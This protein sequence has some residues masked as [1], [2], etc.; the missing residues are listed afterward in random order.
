MHVHMMDYNN[1]LF[2]PAHFSFQTTGIGHLCLLIFLPGD[3]REEAISSAYQGPLVLWLAQSLP[4]KWS[5]FFPMF[6][7][8]LRQKKTRVFVGVPKHLG[9]KLD[10]EELI[11]RGHVSFLGCNG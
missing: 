6:F 2:F 9:K 8:M 7:L 10:A 1:S 4:R 3:Q 5:R 11:F